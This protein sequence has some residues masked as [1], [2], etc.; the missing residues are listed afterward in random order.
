[1]ISVGS[2]AGEI[3]TY[4]GKAYFPLPEILVCVLTFI[5]LSIFPESVPGLHMDEAWSFVRA[6]EIASGAHPLNGTNGYTGTIF[7]YLLVPVFKVFGYKVAAMKI[8]CAFLN[9][10]TVF[11]AMLFVRSL[12]VQKNYHL[13]FGL[14]L[15]TFPMFLTHSRF[16][17]EITALNPLFFFIGLFLA[18]EFLKH[19]INYFYRTIFSDK[20]SASGR[21]SAKE[22]LCLFR[23]GVIWA[24]RV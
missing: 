16:C 4:M 12:Y 5:L 22:K 14:L 19:L 17:I 6:H 18:I 23:G 7:Q 20:S 3:S 13:Y 21:D 11:F 8:A 24:C 15:C 10:L 9:T 1:M 2:Y